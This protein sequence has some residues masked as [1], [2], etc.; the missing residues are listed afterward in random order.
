MLPLSCQPRHWRGRACSRE[1]G[2]GGS[3]PLEAVTLT[4]CESYDAR[5]GQCI[6]DVF[7]HVSIRRNLPGV[8]ANEDVATSIETRC[9][10]ALSMP[11]DLHPWM[12]GI[13]RTKLMLDEAVAQR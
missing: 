10:P 13:G 12:L 8:S 11:L 4:V 1:A 3:R 6:Q 5:L 9:V 7:T 2:H